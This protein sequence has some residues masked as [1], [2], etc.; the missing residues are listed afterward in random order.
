MPL[1][2]KKEVIYTTVTTTSYLPRAMLMAKSVKKHMPNCKVIACIVED[3]IP[4]NRE[5]LHNYFDDVVLASDIGISNFRQFV[6]QY[7]QAQASCACKA[8]LMLY[9][10]KSYRNHDYFIFL[11]SDTK[12]F[13]PFYELL[14]HLE[15][16]DIILSPH[17]IQFDEDNLLNHLRVIHGAGIFNTGLF[18]IKRSDEAYKFLLWWAKILLRFCYVD[19]DIGLFNEQKWLDLATGQFEFFVQNDPGYNVGPWNFHER[20][21]TQGRNKEYRVN[22]KP[23]RLFHFSGIF[24]GYF[25]QEIEALGYNQMLLNNIKTKYIQGLEILDKELLSSIP[26]SYGYFDSGHQIDYQSRIIFRENQELFKDVDNPFSKDNEF[27]LS[28][29]GSK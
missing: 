10:L 29:G 19:Y 28:S 6:F 14:D 22:E 13:G 21:L 18:A 24:D 20:F 26:W 11:D 7:D 9:L 23:L 16:N 15:N 2:D 1:I 4:V 5:R 3:K 8:Q 25:D 17:F 12:V 27:F